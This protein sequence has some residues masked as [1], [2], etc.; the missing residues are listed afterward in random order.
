MPIELKPL[1]KPKLKKVEMLCDN[2]IDNKLTKFPVIESCFSKTNFTILLGLMGQGK[3]T[4]A[5]QL[6]S[7][8]YK[9]CFSDIYVVMPENSIN[10]IP[11]KH[12]FTKHLD[13]EE[14]IYHEYSPETLETIYD[15]LQNNSADGNHSLLVLDDFGGEYKNKECEKLLNRII[16]RMRHLRCSILILA[17]NVF[18]LPKKMREVASCIISYNLGKS[19]MEKIFREFFNMKPDQFIDVMKLYKE[20]HDYLLLNVRKQKLYYKLEAEVIINDEKKSNDDI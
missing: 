8:V 13:P 18:Q 6:I 17:Q 19:Q 3:T 5:T 7:S 1:Q 2:I 4:L 11:E 15:K 20:P 9:N 10:S 14:H 12:N 16:I